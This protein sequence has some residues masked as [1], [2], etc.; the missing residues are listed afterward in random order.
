MDLFHG[1]GETVIQKRGHWTRLGTSLGTD[2][3]DQ[4]K[5]GDALERLGTVAIVGVGL[6]GGSIGM[7][8][9]SRGVASRVLGLGRDPR[10]LG[11][12]CELGAIDE[13]SV[14]RPAAL[15]RADV[16]V[17]CT[18][19]GR[20][21]DDLLDVAG[22][23]PHCQLI[24]DAGSTKRAIIEDLERRAPGS[25]PFV[26]AHPIAGSE[27]SGVEY[28]RP[29]LFHD[30]TC[31]LTP[32]DR[33]PPP[34]L[35]LARR[36]WQGTGARVVEMSPAEHDRALARTSHLPHVLASALAAEVP[37]TWLPLAAGAFRDGTRV[38]AADAA[39]WVDILLQNRDELASA[40]GDL[41]GSL[42][43]FLERLRQ[44]DADQLRQWW[45]QGRD[46]RAEFE[47]T[48]FAEPSPLPTPAHGA[49]P[50]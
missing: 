20:L 39:L 32:T 5:L 3:P 48:Y 10:R 27:Q 22:L 41:M 13:F 19:V 50:D 47:R 45:E 21:A 40:V 1:G 33:T 16:V 9:R 8:L 44:A 29:D 23:A 28:A 43:D 14:D 31:V 49:G 18:P 17:V 37:P 4:G 2:R 11:R 24:T 34:A 25:L 46:R 35:A 6:I 15:A 42:S 36:F 30:R 7:A 26:G 12:A 38:A